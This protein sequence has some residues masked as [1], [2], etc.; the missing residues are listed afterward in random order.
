[1]C[2]SVI[3]IYALGSV[4]QGA[5]KVSFTACHSG[6][7]KSACTSP[8]VIS[9]SPIMSRVDNSSFVIRIP[10]KISLALRAS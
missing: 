10:Y 4:H 2:I 3:R 1:M 9:T 6:K 5:K 7:L 8:K